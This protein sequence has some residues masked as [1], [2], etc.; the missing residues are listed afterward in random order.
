MGILSYRTEWALLVFLLAVFFLPACSLLRS[1]NEEAKSKSEE[2]MTRD[3]DRA[4]KKQKDSVRHKESAKPKEGDKKT[5]KERPSY[6][7]SETRVHDLVHTVLDVEF[8]LK[9]RYLYGKAEIDLTPHFYPTDSL[10]L[11]AKGFDIHELAL[12]SD[13]GRKKLA[14]DYDERKLRI[15]L[16]STYTRRDTFRI[17]I[18]Y[19]AKP[20]ELKRKGS[21]AIS[22]AQ[23]L[24]F[25]DPMDKD[26]DKPTQIWT[27][28]ETES[29]S[30]WFPTIDAPN[31]KMTQ[32]ISITVRD[33]FKTLSN[34]SLQ[35][36]LKEGNGMRTDVWVQEKPHPPYLTM[37]AIGDFA[38]VEDRWNDLS[39]DYWVEHAYKESAMEIFGNTP[40]MI[41]FFSD[42]LDFEYPWAKYDQV[43]VRDFVSGAME[44][45]SAT[46]HG[47]RQRKTER[48]LIDG[49]HEPT[50]AHELI[51]HWF[52][53]VVTCE[54]WANLPLNEAFATY[55]EYLWEEHK[56]GREAAD[57]LLQKK[58]RRYL[59]Y[60]RQ[61]QQVNLIRYRYKDKEA[62][63]DP[64]SYN[65][66]GHILHMLRKY[67]GDDAFFQA[68][69]KYLHDN[70]YE[71]VEVHDLRLAFESVTGEDL[72]W[73]FDQWF[74]DK[75]HP[76]LDIQHRYAS[77]QG[78]YR[79]IVKQ[80]QDLEKWPLYK[81]PIKV[82][83]YYGKERVRRSVTIDAS[84]DTFSFEVKR[85][86][87]LVNV[88]A[89]KMLLC[90][91]EDHKSTSAYIHQYKHAPLYLD[92][93][94]ALAHCKGKRD[95]LAAG[96]VLKAMK[97]EHPR[98]R[99]SAL[100][101]MS[102][103]FRFYPEEARKTLI[104]MARSDAHSQTRAMALGQLKEQ[105]PE[106]DHMATYKKAL[107][108][109]SYMVIAFGLRGIA[110]SYP[111]KGVELAKK[112]E[113][114]K[115]GDVVVAVASIY[116]SSGVPGKLPFFTQNLDRLGVRS[117]VGCLKSFSEYLKKQEFSSVES[118]LPVF[119]KKA[120]EGGNWYVRRTALQA[121]KSLKKK[122]KEKKKGLKKELS[123][124]RE[125]EKAEEKALSEK[126]KKV[127][128]R[129]KGKLR[130]VKERIQTIQKSLDRIE[131]EKKKSRSRD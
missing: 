130:K 77:D 69:E 123:E 78:I 21:Q 88:D 66:G 76:V 7:G 47:S 40:E 109:S 102:T 46:V 120:I 59:L 114:S 126:D 19:T 94:E 42:T 16:D 52:G 71:P 129:K 93:Y 85:K 13:T 23:G 115:N 37:M 104:R 99:L 3:Q 92:R 10:R 35:Y 33:S 4:E 44:N 34:G 122:Y 17:Y 108:D 31:Q 107:K 89:Q 15:D 5:F 38:V 98:I 28:G 57:R 72:H 127:R 116:A 20:T 54:S 106:T 24:Y 55:G 43:V 11:D 30:C 117:K 82:D 14:Y 29:S 96:V 86:P 49:D 97:D 87:D 101:S 27:Q 68:L 1:S 18:D 73:F 58:L 105:L 95:S 25:I 64:F 110:E 62:M 65:K 9:K 2:A 12:V 36:S 39:V 45:T 113:D 83:L 118:S 6:R 124:I 128:Q 75:G 8:D 48:E 112:F 70:A 41:G 79:V 50:I 80:E 131:K 121:I 53:N 32:E 100:Q 51:H 26:A 63:F 74:L 111:Q 90:E 67:V 125:K 22:S 60:A 56:Y 103:V 91:K 84:V 119:E 61:N 81:L